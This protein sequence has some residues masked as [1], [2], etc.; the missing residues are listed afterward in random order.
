MTL[1][2]DQQETY[3]YVVGR[4]NGLIL[5]KGHAGCG[6]TYLA[7]QI[8]K[9]FLDRDKRVIA[10]S[11]THQAKLQFSQSLASN[12]KTSTISS[13]L[14]SKASRNPITGVLEFTQGKITE[15]DG[16]SYELIVV[17]E[18]SMIGEE[19][20]KEL[21]K[22]KSNALIVFLGDFHQL[23]PVKKKDGS[24]IYKVMKTFE[25]TEQHRNSGNVLKL[26][27]QLRTK[28]VYPK[29]NC[30]G[31]T[32]YDDTVDFLA[33][34]VDTIKEYPNPYNISYLAFTNKA[35][36]DVRNFLHAELY[37]KEAYVPGQ[38]L[39]LESRTEI[40]NRSEVV[41]IIEVEKFEGSLFGQRIEFYCLDVINVFSDVR[42]K[43]TV[44]SYDDQDIV[45][46]T[47]SHFHQ[48][49]FALYQKFKN[50][51]KDVKSKDA[52][53]DIKEKI[54]EVDDKITLVSSPFALTVHKSQGRSIP[55]VFLD[56][57]NIDRYGRDYD[58]KLKLM[59][60]GASRTKDNLNV[61][62]V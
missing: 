31:I 5:I 37:G 38:H 23:S 8:I 25:L 62:R 34:L 17:D 54:Q 52:W 46:E 21:I 20:L 35:V 61:I 12:V 1:S 58:T 14:K 22:L 26:C 48:E 18:C 16:K 41:E 59:Y 42:G 15:S 47:L 28:L 39:R 6:K 10:L 51:P 24:E 36:K 2:K 53:K 55:I 9:N 60:V 33:S 45:E 57:R 13:F 7:I 4:K 32:V 40:G 30:D 44:I 11:P 19:D 50:N 43:I 29:E 56:T 3:D 27:D 49:S